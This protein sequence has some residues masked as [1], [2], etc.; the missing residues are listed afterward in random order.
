MGIG[1]FPTE[2]KMEECRE[3][4]PNLEKYFTQA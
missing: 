4:F 3:I 1:V 2:G